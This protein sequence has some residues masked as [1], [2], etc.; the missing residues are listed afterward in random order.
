MKS[1]KKRKIILVGIGI[2]FICC[3]I[4]IYLVFVKIDNVRLTMM[5]VPDVQE[6]IDIFAELGYCSGG[7]VSEDNTYAEVKL[8]K[9]QRKKWL[10]DL[11]VEVNDFISKANEIEYMNIAMS[12]D[13]KELTVHADKEVSFQTLATYLGA[14]VWDI[15]LIQVLEGE[16]MWSIE[17]T[18]KDIETEQILFQADFPA[19]KIKLDESL[20]DEIEK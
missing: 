14:I 3:A 12:S 9:W 10:N 7:Y 20:W 15:E 17:F 2:M 13:F 6:Q 1:S 8:T 11:Y 5:P 4:P 16:Q 18:A 19:E